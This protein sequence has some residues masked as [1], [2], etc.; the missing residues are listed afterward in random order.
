MCVWR[1]T[2]EADMLRPVVACVQKGGY[3]VEAGKG[4][5]QKKKMYCGLS[6]LIDDAQGA[7]NWRLSVLLSTRLLHCISR[8][9]VYQYTVYIPRYPI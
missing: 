5:T 3:S 7:P 9:T 8:H 2:G 6:L 4:R 1:R